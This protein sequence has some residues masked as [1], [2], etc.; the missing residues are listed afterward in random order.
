MFPFTI[1]RHFLSDN[2]I[3]C[4]N[5]NTFV[6]ERILKKSISIE[7]GNSDYLQVPLVKV[8]SDEIVRIIIDYD[9]YREDGFVNEDPKLT[10]KTEKSFRELISR[11]RDEPGDYIMYNI[12]VLLR[13][14]HL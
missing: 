2:V 13:V 1:I 12:Y 5:R 10:E 9:E 7:I 3:A 8:S 14:L 4:D 6:I 11:K